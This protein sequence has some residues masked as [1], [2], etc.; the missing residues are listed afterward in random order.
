MTQWEQSYT[1][2]HATLVWA[3]LKAAEF[4]TPEGLAHMCLSLILVIRGLC[5]CWEMTKSV[6]DWLEA[7]SRLQHIILVHCIRAKM[8]NT[9]ARD[10]WYFVGCFM[11]LSLTL[12]HITILL[13]IIS[14]RIICNSCLGLLANV[15]V[16]WWERLPGQCLV[17]IAGIVWDS[18]SANEREDLQRKL[19]NSWFPST[20]KKKERRILDHELPPKDWPNREYDSF[21][22]VISKVIPFDQLAFQR[23][24]KNLS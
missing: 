1:M 17:F 21:T 13:R 5:D 3:D 11:I 16:T 6:T 24:F 22:R 12:M 7:W 9:P 4:Y 10:I 23:H 18:A 2:P 8:Q 14:L 20:A 15:H 19:H